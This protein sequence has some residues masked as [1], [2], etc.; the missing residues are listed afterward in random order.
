MRRQGDLRPISI[1]VQAPSRFKTA[2]RNNK[3]VEDRLSE[4]RDDPPQGSQQNK[5]LLIF[6]KRIEL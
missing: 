4:K 5:R 6:K 3:V 2:V 1:L